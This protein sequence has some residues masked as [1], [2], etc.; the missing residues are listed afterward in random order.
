MVA[1]GDILYRIIFLILIALSNPRV[2]TLLIIMQAK[3]VLKEL[4]YYVNKSTEVLIS[5][6]SR[7]R[8]VE[9][10][11]I[12]K[13]IEKYI[14]VFV[15]SPVTLDPV[16]VIKRLEHLMNTHD[17][18]LR[19][20]S[21][22][23]VGLDDR[24]VVNTVMNV[25]AGVNSVYTLYKYLRHLVV[26]ASKSESLLA[27]Y[28]IQMVL[29]RI[30]LLAASYYDAA[31]AFSVIST[32][33]DSAGPYVA[34]MLAREFGT[35]FEKCKY[36]EQAC[37][38]SAEWE[39]R[40]I[41]IVKACGPA[42]NLCNFGR[43]VYNLGKELSDSL[44]AIITIDAAL[45]LEGEPTGD[46]QVGIGAAIGDPG[47]EK[48]KMETIAAELNVPLM[49][50]IIKE[51]LGEAIVP[52]SKEIADGCK[53]AK[54]EVLE[55]IKE[56]VPEGGSVIVVGVGNTSGVA[57]G[58]EEDFELPEAR[59][60]VDLD[61]YMERKYEI[62]T[63][64]VDEEGTVIRR[65]FKPGDYVGKIVEENGRRMIIEE[66]SAKVPREISEFGMPL[67]MTSGS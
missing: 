36:D 58:L 16:G 3:S 11:D 7:W 21:R 1:T 14:D 57:N 66:V 23:I 63:K 28:Q 22:R 12:K 55:L 49:A 2:Q 5:T 59:I 40:K 18:Y 65:T 8:D 25:L 43:V 42:P 60:T 54:E 24:N 6:I 9:K 45:K 32:I 46:V 64:L 30:R 19:S 56:M 26:S 50:V 17:E 4:D 20:A 37:V 47:H 67:L 34:R 62:R 38:A 15:I 53:K 52:M 39:G 41:Y 29:P 44:K 61:P 13:V 33:G 31:K 10:E 48:Y 27:A 51:S 35:E